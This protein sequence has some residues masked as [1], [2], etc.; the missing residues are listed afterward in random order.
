[1][2]S[3]IFLNAIPT[4]N[5]SFEGIIIESFVFENESPYLDSIIYDSVVLDIE[6]SKY[7]YFN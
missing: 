1:M 5:T 3:D 2:P 6:T 7:I 4:I